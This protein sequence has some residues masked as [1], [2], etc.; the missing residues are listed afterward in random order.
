MDPTRPLDNATPAKDLGARSV[1]RIQPTGSATSAQAQ[2]QAEAAPTTV[3]QSVGDTRRLMET[4]RGA[5]KRADNKQ[6]SEL[7]KAIANGTFKVD[8]KK[9]ADRMVD[10]AFG[11]TPK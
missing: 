10:D 5:L 7:R 6:V 2:S 8:T 3:A 11:E 9:L 4:A 1:G